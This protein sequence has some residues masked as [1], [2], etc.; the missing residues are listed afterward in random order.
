MGSALTQ[1]IKFILK[2]WDYLSAVD[3]SFILLIIFQINLQFGTSD[4][5]STM[6]YEIINRA[7]Y[8][9]NNFGTSLEKSE[10]IAVSLEYS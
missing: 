5:F 2:G 9:E 6:E 4:G 10:G 3:G 7:H 1:V 8:S